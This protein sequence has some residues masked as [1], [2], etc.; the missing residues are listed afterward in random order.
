MSEA[1]NSCNVVMIFV[2]VKVACFGAWKYLDKCA[3]GRRSLTDEL[4]CEIKRETKGRALKVLL[5]DKVK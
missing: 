4:H 5:G 1:P 2:F 3:K